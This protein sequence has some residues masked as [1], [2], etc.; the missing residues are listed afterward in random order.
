MKAGLSDHQLVCVS[1]TNAIESD[2]IALLLNPVASTIP[3]S[4]GQMKN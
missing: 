3:N 1:P 2:L 4:W